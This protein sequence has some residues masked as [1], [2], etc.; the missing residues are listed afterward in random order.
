M[1]SLTDSCNYFF[2]QKTIVFVKNK[3]STDHELPVFE[4]GRFYHNNFHICFRCLLNPNFYLFMNLHLLPLNLVVV[5]QTMKL[6]S[7]QPIYVVELIPFAVNV[8]PKGKKF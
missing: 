6:Q 3:K 1:F 8:F 2:L 5:I 7:V 4:N